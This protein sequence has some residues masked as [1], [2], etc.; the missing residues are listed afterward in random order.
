MCLSG[1]LSYSPSVQDSVLPGDELVSYSHVPL[2]LVLRHCR[3]GNCRLY[4]QVY[5]VC[6]VSEAQPQERL[7]SLAAFGF[8]W[9]M[10]VHAYCILKGCC[11][12]VHTVNHVFWGEVFEGELVRLN[13]E[14]LLLVEKMQLNYL[15]RT[16][17]VEKLSE[18]LLSPQC[19]VQL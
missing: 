17:C 2:L 15:V 13:S 14:V 10:C 9:C 4:L 1:P 18:M 8:G 6:R 12:S 3:Y 11:F 5:R 16:E 19:A 7:D